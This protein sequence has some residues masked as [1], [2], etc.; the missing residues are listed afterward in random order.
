MPLVYFAFLLL[1]EWGKDM[2]KKR[3]QNKAGKKRQEIVI[4]SN[5]DTITED[6]L[7]QAIVKAHAIIANNKKEDGQNKYDQAKWHIKALYLLNVVMF[8]WKLNKKFTLSGP[9]YDDILVVVVSWILEIIGTLVWIMGIVF[10]VCSVMTLG[11]SGMIMQLGIMI[12]LGV[13]FMMFGS[14]SVLAGKEFSKVVDS[15][16]IYAY[17][18]CILAL[19]S[20]VVAVISLVNQFM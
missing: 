7:V 6:M 11:Q 17:S 13:G 19:I 8:P 15:N 9:I 16:R 3:K 5:T 2:G 10:I 20:C 12:T 1:T 18:A 14:M 4:Q